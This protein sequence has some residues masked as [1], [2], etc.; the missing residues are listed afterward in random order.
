MRSLLARQTRQRAQQTHH[1]DHPFWPVPVEEAPF[2]TQG[3]KQDLP[4]QA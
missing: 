4:V 2:W 3:I 1:N